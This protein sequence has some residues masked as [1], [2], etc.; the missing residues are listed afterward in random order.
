MRITIADGATGPGE[1]RACEIPRSYCNPFYF[2]CSFV[3]PH[4][5]EYQL[6]I[7]NLRK[8]NAELANALHSA[9]EMLDKHKNM[10]T[11][12]SDVYAII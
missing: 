3:F 8:E 9:N 2:C 7:A 6:E 5:V 10:D 1:R 4:F 11:D 12:D